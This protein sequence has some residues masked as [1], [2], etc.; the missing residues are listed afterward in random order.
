[1][2]IKSYVGAL[3]LLLSFSSTINAQ[4][5]PIGNYGAKADG[6]DVS[7]ALVSAWKEACASLNPATV[8]IPAGT[9]ALSE[10]TL[11]GPCKNPLEFQLQGTLQAP[12]DPS[13]FK[14]DGWIVF[15]NMD[16]FTLSGSG[17]FDGKGQI[18]WTKNDCHKNTDCRT[19]PTN[20]RFNF[21]SNAIVHDVTTLDSKNFHVTVMGCKNQTFQHFHVSAPADSIN[22]DGIHIG[23][24]TGINILDTD[25]KTGDDCVSLGDGSEQV[26]VKGVSCGPGHGISVGSLGKYDNESPVSGVF[27]TNCTITGADNGVRIK[28]WPASKPGIASDMHFEDIQMN[29]VLNP[30]LIDQGYCP[31]NQ[32]K[33]GIPSQ[34]KISKVSFKKIRGTSKS[35]VAVKL[36]CSQSVPC[37]EVEI[38]DIDLA[39]QGPEGPATSECSNVKPLISGIQNPPACAKVVS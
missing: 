31:F 30:V 6:S 33:A 17:T 36:A 4:V 3:L 1:M 15:Q 37:A 14:T 9:F 19:L 2:A 23:R 11:E 8:Q 12:A 34:V 13:S 29:D 10:V 16:G 26:T 35:Q 27:V 5:F 20:L 18:A 21:V 25:I 32:C 24:S 38:A 28:T 39:Y 7:Q 22:T